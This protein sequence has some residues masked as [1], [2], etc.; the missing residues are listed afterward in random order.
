MGKAVKGCWMILLLPVSGLGWL[1]VFGLLFM[2]LGSMPD[3]NGNAISPIVNWGI[4]LGMAIVPLII[5]SNIRGD[6]PDDK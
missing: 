1:Y 3:Q 5:L 2:N 4:A 6:I